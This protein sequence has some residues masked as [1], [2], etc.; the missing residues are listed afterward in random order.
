MRPILRLL[1]VTASLEAFGCA[2]TEHPEEEP[3]G[4]PNFLVIMADD[5]G[6]SDL[7]VFGSEI[8]T[9]HLDAL[10]GAGVLLTNFRVAPN[11]SPTR[12]MLLSGTDTHPAGLGTMAGDADENQQGQPGYEGY[13]SDRVVTVSSLLQ[14]SGYYTAMAGKWHLG[15]TPELSPESRGFDDAFAIVPGGASHFSDAAPVLGGSPPIYRENGVDVDLPE[16]FYSSTFYTDKIIDYI[17]SSLE[18]DQPFFAYTVY[19]APHWPLQAPDED[20]SLYA[21]VYDEGYDA[22]RERRTRNLIDRGVV[23]DVPVPDRVSWV[24]AWENLD[25]DAR[26]VEARRMEIYAAMVENM[27][28]NIGRLLAFLE[29]AGVADNTFVV[30]L[31]DN[32]AEGNNIGTMYDN[33][34]WIPTRFDTSYENMGRMDSYVWTGPGWAQAQ[35]APFRLFKSFPSEGGVRAP[36]IFKDP[37]RVQRTGLV[38]P[39]STVKDITPTILELAG[40]EHPKSFAG[41]EVAP[42]QGTS[43]AAYLAGTAPSIHDDDEVMGW[44]LFGRRAIYKGQWK[45]V[46]LW[47]PY[48]TGAWELFHL[49][50]DPSESNDL[51]GDE[52]EKLEELLAAWHDY[53][54]DNGVL[55]PARDMGYGMVDG[56]R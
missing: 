8:R 42:L 31:S 38:A 21:G 11:C 29:E 4:R 10:A 1:V 32:G 47:E 41:R 20:L 34:T 35:S 43:M 33:E 40:V 15:V 14:A 5:L 6:F 28:R 50:S 2:A 3:P 54:E 9:P 18:G 49:A 48:G 45:L 36:A 51:S 27:D 16:G 12:A 7:G 53:A 30:F 46:W 25:A 39:F 26:R 19:T 17:S 56:G 24:P 52:P 13:L 23:P 55:L 44:E 37:S 22:L